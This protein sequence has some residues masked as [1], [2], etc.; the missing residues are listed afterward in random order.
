MS[1]DGSLP[2]LTVRETANFLAKVFVPTTAKGPIIRRPRMVALGEKLGFDERAVATLAQLAAKYPA[3]PVLLRLPLRRQAVVLE[4]GHVHRILAETPDPFATASSEKQ[5]ALAHFQPRNSLIST[6]SERSVRR[7]LQ[8]QVL[9]S[10]SQVH[11][12]AESFLPVVAQE[13]EDLVSAARSAGELTWD[14]FIQSWYRVV[15]RV[16]F[17]DSAA[18]DHEVTE[19]LQQLRSDANW[20]FLKPRNRRLRSKFLGAVEQRMQAAPPGSLASVMAG[21]NTQEDA[22]PVEQIPQWLFAFDPAGMTTFR[23]LAAVTA[24]PEVLSRALQ[25]VGTSPG[26]RAYL[27][28]LRAC[29]LESLRLWPTT[30]MVLRQ[31]TDDVVWD[32]GT[33]RRKSGVLIYAPFFHR[34]ERTV[35]NPHA[36]TPERW[37]NGDGDWALIPF[38]EGPAACPGRH[39]VL[40]LTSAFLSHLIEGQGLQLEPA[41]RLNA[42]ARMPGTLNNYSLRFTVRQDNR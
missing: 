34:D 5:A 32:A 41:G 13:A 29:V 31:T 40:M 6:G 19:M 1:S 28:W 38:S 17:G 8:E 27:P 35:P 7:A 9:D 20:A 25:E 26:Q 11:N 16:V 21:M 23:T 4:H 12:L 2:Q 15:R 36:Y 18:D 30:P 24:H 37:L 3:S 14:D 42:G 39:L 22:A 33:M 10:D